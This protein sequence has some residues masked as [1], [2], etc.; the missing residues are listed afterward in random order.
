MSKMK[1]SIIIVNSSYRL[2]DAVE[3][4][5]LTSAFDFVNYTENTYNNIIV[6]TLIIKYF[7]LKVYCG[8]ETCSKI[9]YFLNVL[10][11]KI[12]QHIRDICKGYIIILTKRFL[13]FLSNS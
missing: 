10:A 3:C 12:I 13:I 2:R 9:S 6:F 1:K 5:L 4:R 7:N 8:Q 11:G